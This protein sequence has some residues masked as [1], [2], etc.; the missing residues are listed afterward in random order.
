MDYY[1]LGSYT[2]KVTTA[3]P[4]AQLWFDRG[5]NWLFGFNHAEA[6]AC[7]R[8]AL[9]QLRRSAS[10]KPDSEGVGGANRLCFRGSGGPLVQNSDE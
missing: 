6:I 8:K 3:V 10:P 7:F 4:E 1:D 2:R 9:A 5:L